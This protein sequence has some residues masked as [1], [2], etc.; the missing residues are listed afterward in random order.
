MVGLVIVSHS[1]SLAVAVRELAAAVGTT[2]IP[3]A[4]AGG[5]GT[6]HAELGTDATEIMDALLE[7]DSPEGSVVLVD[8][9][10]AVLST[11]T[12]LEFVGESCGVRDMD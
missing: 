7:V 3:I 5:T 11:E 10:S 4:C 6:D 12:A 8:L 1:K 2:P 9:G